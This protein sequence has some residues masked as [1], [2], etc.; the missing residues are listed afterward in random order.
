MKESH[1]EG[2]AIYTGPEL[3][4][5]SRKAGCEALPPTAPTPRLRR[6]IPRHRSPPLHNSTG[7]ITHTS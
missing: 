2:L 3:C 6:P 4:V 5:A 7:R 1:S